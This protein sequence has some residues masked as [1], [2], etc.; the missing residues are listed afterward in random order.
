MNALV[1]DKMNHLEVENLKKPT[2][3]NNEVLIKVAYVGVCGTDKA[4]YQG[5]PGSA[6]AVPPIVLGHE[7]SGTVVEIGESVT[8][9][10]VGDRV[11]I[12]P[13]IYCHKCDFCRTNRP[14][15]CTNLSAVGVTRN[16]GLEE[17]VAV[18]EEVAYKLPDNVSF[19]QAAL[20]EPLSCVVHGVDLLAIKPFQEAIVLGDG[21]TGQLFVKTLKAYGVS[22]VTI[23]TRHLDDEKHV[24]FL[25]KVVG[26]DEVVDARSNDFDKDYDVVVEAVGSA[27]VQEQ[28]V[29]AAAHGG[30]VLMFG[31][32]KPE[33]KFS[34]SSYEIFQKQLTVQGSFINP[35]TF[36]AAIAMIAAGKIDPSEL[37][38]ME[39]KAAKM[40]DYLS[41]KIRT[42][43]A[44]LNI[45]AAF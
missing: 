33:Q 29:K 2:P 13:N 38:S 19:K 12:D 35:Y 31:V 18:P 37:V 15:L 40:N 34:V 39:L 6:D 7:D 36:K 32:G 5:L 22:K 28:A 26:A 44:V 11:A 10:E 27:D 3:K 9:F 30:Q 1:L 20:T 14:E 4:L 21:F 16:G 8:N 41:G 42:N 23:S 45:E 24:D 25:K 43:K 17:Y